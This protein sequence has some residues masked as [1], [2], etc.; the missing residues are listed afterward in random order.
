VQNRRRP[1]K[2]WQG[3]GSLSMTTDA[4]V[5]AGL[6]L[7]RGR[8]QV[9]VDRIGLLE[10]IR[11]E[12]SINGAAKA[13]GLSYKGAWD[14]VQALNN[15]F[16][17]PL[18]STRAGGR[19]GGLAQVTPEGEALIAAFRSVETEL[20]HV[21]DA[22]QKRLADPAAAPLQTLLWSLAMKTS[23]RNALR[24]TVTR[25][26]P[27]AVNAEV[28]LDI[29]GGCEITAIITRHSIDDLGLQPGRAAIALIKSSM[30]LLATGGETLR[31]SARN[32]LRGTVVQ[33]E[34]GAVNCEVV[35]EIGP[36]KTL[37]ATITRESVDELDLRAGEPATALIK[38]SHV[39]LAVE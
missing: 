14:A 7:K 16:D 30:V 27:G 21:L 13:Q 25:V 28:V 39:I 35:L 37:V 4:A 2:F 15:L 19:Q 18:V 24:G 26:T 5:T 12:G 22:F 29:G 34:E 38:A 8:G 31:T 6:V 20:A 33:V 17:Q 10:A 36:A 1:S 23:A 3:A 11:R 9:G 32:Q